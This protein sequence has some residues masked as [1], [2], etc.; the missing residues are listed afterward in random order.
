MASLN[1]TPNEESTSGTMLE[2]FQLIDE[3]EKRFI[4]FQVATLKETRLTIPQYFIL[5]LLSEKDGRPFKELAE[6]LACTRATVTGIVDT[7][8]K[9]GLVTRNPNL[10][11]RRSLLVRL[12]EKGRTLI[13]SSPGLEETYGTCCDVLPPAEMRELNRLLKKLSDSL[14]F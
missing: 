2:V 5:S 1:T 13:Q 10:S 14:P 6:V 4:Q 9:K 12:T 3:L 11:D 8:E 7:L